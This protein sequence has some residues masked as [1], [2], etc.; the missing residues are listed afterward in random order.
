[1]ETFKCPQCTKEFPQQCK[2]N[3][4]VK[5][6]HA[7]DLDERC[8]YPLPESGR[9][10]QYIFRAFALAEAHLRQ[11]HG[12]VACGQC[13]E[14]L[15]K[16]G[17]E[18]LPKPGQRGATLMSEKER[19]THLAQVHLRMYCTC[20]PGVIKYV[21]LSENHVCE[22]HFKCQCAVKPAPEKGKRKMNNGRPAI[23]WVKEGEHTCV[24]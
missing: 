11:Q 22:K 4:H 15:K 7:E 8:F 12:L 19:I 17:G 21:L 3:A 20:I 9:D 18:P 6:V 1:L 14:I 10:C 24:T 23:V 2:L 5:K 13:V 16:S